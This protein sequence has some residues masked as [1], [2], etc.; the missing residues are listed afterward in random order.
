M[1]TTKQTE[2]TSEQKNAK[3]HVCSECNKKK[4]V[5]NCD[6]CSFNFCADHIVLAHL[7]QIEYQTIASNFLTENSLRTICKDCLAIK[8]IELLSAIEREYL[9]LLLNCSIYTEKAQRFFYDKLTGKK[10]M[11]FSMDNSYKSC[12]ICMTLFEKKKTQGKRK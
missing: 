5:W 9:P 7:D 12:Y 2:M 10:K 11:K 3:N 4:F 8:E 1:S 6:V